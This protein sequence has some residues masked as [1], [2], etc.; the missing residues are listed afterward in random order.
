MVGKLDL[1]FNMESFCGLNSV[2][3]MLVLSQ[4]RPKCMIIVLVK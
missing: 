3:L 4:I 1:D 2:K